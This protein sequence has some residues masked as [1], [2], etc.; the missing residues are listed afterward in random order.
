MLRP[1]SLVSDEIEYETGGASAAEFRFPDTPKGFARCAIVGMR[2]NITG[3]DG[4]VQVV[5]LWGTELQ[6]LTVAGRNYFQGATPF[7]L[8]GAETV[9][10]GSGLSIGFPW[11]NRFPGS[12]VPLPN[13]M[14][15]QG[16]A[17]AGIALG[18]SDEV[19]MRLFRLGDG[20]YISRVTLDCVQW[21]D[22]KNEPSNAGINAQW[23]ALRFS[24]L[25]EPYWVGNKRTGYPA[26]GTQLVFDEHPQPPSARVL[27]RTGIRGA[28]LDLGGIAFYEIGDAAA[29]T[30][31]NLS[32]EVSSSFQRPPQNDFVPF[33]NIIGLN[34]LEIV[35]GLVDL[36]EDERSIVRLNAVGTNPGEPERLLYV[37][38][39]FEGRLEGAPVLEAANAIS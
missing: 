9:S 14:L 13:T 6:R 20:A 31:N 35:T 23:D 28:L 25:G 26:A 27:R 19:R 8:I 36:A 33:R 22:G 37:L 4:I 34:N 1:F 18:P 5:G 11:W 32:A 7:P 17:G 3:V 16:I 12:H 21:P 24:G 39:M 15:G 38:H 10:G 30:A 29:A 2:A